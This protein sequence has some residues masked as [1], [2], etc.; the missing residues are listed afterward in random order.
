[1]NGSNDKIGSSE[2]PCA[3]Y[4]IPYRYHFYLERGNKSLFRVHI[5]GGH[6]TLFLPHP[7]CLKQEESTVFFVGAQGILDVVHLSGCSISV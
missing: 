5:N 3:G 1:M 7:W 6:I 4:E 2:R